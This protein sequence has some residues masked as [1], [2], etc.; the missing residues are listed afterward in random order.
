MN[1]VNKQGGKSP[2][3]YK[4]G[5]TFKNKENRLPN[6]T[7]YREYDVNPY[8]RGVNRGTQRLVIGKNGKAYYTKNHYK[9]FI[10]I[11]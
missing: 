10:R 7:T 4:G 6:N 5:R 3:G 8:K 9:S 1:E 11:K 2:K